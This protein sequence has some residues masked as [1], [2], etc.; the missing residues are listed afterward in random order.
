MKVRCTPFHKVFVRT[1]SHCTAPYVFAFVKSTYKVLQTR[2]RW[3]L[4]TPK[5]TDTLPSASRFGRP[6]SPMAFIKTKP[7]RTS[8][9]APQGL[10]QTLRRKR[11][12]E[13]LRPATGEDADAAIVA[14]DSLSSNRHSI[15]NAD[16]QPQQQQ[17]QPQPQHEE[18]IESM[19]KS[20]S[21]FIDSESQSPART[22]STRTSFS[23]S[24]LATPKTRA[25]RGKPRKVQP[26]RRQI[27]TA[28]PSPLRQSYVPVGADA[29]AA[30]E[31]LTEYG[32]P[33][34]KEAGIWDQLK[35]NTMRAFMPSSYLDWMEHGW[36][37]KPAY[38]T[39]DPAWERKGKDWSAKLFGQS[40]SLTLPSS[41]YRIVP[42]NIAH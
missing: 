41:K 26:A 32:T 5:M 4:H 16:Q 39:L 19:Y 35:L 34:V 29:D 23:F 15:A 3:S 17:P 25:K 30:H 33:L 36:V 6:L 31:S 7:Q 27:E 18:S 10:Q 13:P 20:Y 21:S 24:P 38:R 9:L 42:V 2:T 11:K 40:R 22:V 12:L 1:F 37:L 28:K 8:H 14:A